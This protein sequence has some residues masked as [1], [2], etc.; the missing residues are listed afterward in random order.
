MAEGC[1]LKVSSLLVSFSRFFNFVLQILAESAKYLVFFSLML[2]M[3]DTFL[4]WI[5][6]FSKFHYYH[7]TICRKNMSILA[8]VSYTNMNEC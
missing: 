4:L 6:R 8:C 5:I 7:S 3:H 2:N 1:K